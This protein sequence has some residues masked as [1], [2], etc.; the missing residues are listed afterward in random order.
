MDAYIVS[1]L[2]LCKGDKIGDLHSKELETFPGPEKVHRG[3]ISSRER[4]YKKD[5]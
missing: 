2:S 3:A 1:D 4:D 5:Q